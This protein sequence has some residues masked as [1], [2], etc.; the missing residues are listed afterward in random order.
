VDTLPVDP[1]TLATDLHIEA[2]Y[3]LTEALVEAENQMR[4]RVEL[5][6]EVVFETDEHG[7]LVFLNGAWRTLVGEAPDVALGRPLEAFFP[8]DSRP[9]LREALLA[10][11][12]TPP[13]QPIRLDRSDGRS[14]WVMLSAA[15]IRTGGT[16]GVIHDVTAEKAAQDELAKLSVVASSTDNMVIITDAKGAIEWVNRAFET[17]TGYHLDEIRGC[18][19]GRLLQGPGTDHRAI[20]RIR[21]ALRQG[22]SIEEE[23]LNYTKTGEPYWSNLQITAIRDDSD[24]ILRFISVQSDTTERKRYVQE[25]LEQK[26]ALEERVQHRTAEL[27]KAKELAEA[28]TSAKSS[29]IAN[30]SHE[31]RT[32]LNAIIGL[33]HLCLQTRLTDRQQDYL[34]KTAKAARNLMTLISDVL[35]FSK[36]EAGAVHIETVPFHLSQLL[37][38]VQ[39]IMG[40]LAEQ[41]GLRFTVHAPH[42]GDDVVIGDPYRAE[43]VLLNLVNNAVKFTQ[44]GSVEV[45]CT[46]T[47][48]ANAR[49]IV[50]FQVTDTGIGITDEQAPR[51]F[52]A[53]SQ[54]DSSTTRQYGGTGLGL[55][56]SRQLTHQMGGEIGF[57]S[58]PGEGSQFWFTIEVDRPDRATLPPPS[59]RQSPS[60]SDH[61]SLR[62]RRILVVEDNEFN[63][64][65]AAELL[66]TMGARVTVAS[67]GQEALDILALSGPFD[68]VL[69]DVQMPEMD[70]LETTR[71]IRMQ[72]RLSRIPIIAMTANASPEDRST[73]LS[74]GMDDFEAKPIE[75]ERLYATLARWLEDHASVRRTPPTTVDRE[76]LARLLHHDPTKVERFS[77]HFVTTTAASVI[78]MQNALAH[79]NRADI[80]RVAHRVKSAAATVGASKIASTC[81]ALER[82]CTARADQEI[83]ELVNSLADLL[84]QAANEMNVRAPN[85]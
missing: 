14:L 48:A 3:R 49:L 38:N 50:R 78:E 33:T 9:A 16:V 2:T 43:Q 17:R 34:E 12:D 5:L 20:S 63:Q 82:A 60:E 42:V 53:F 65:I 62:G 59:V 26:A 51:L 67:N 31:I 24:Q 1:R 35:D 19:P 22:Q 13:R 4:R 70:G 56:I 58:T 81:A 39:S 68:A 28:A 72:S 83:G 54:A 7:V 32:P 11:S 44:R 52:Q 57:T 25:V 27:A 23:V 10:T 47:E 15:P 77:D 45:N 66:E 29:F 84:R 21:H 64:Q 73:C 75:P 8:A 80:A 37:N 76:V 6:R 71:R 85:L 18:S 36:I 79:R 69:M 55:A 41:K 74:A 61:Q 30:V 46:V 40:T